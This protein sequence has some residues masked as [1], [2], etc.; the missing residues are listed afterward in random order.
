MST[1]KNKKKQK[2]A[3]TRLLPPQLKQNPSFR[4]VFRFKSTGGT[5]NVYRNNILS[6]FSCASAASTAR[7]FPI[8]AIKIRKVSMWVLDPNPTSLQEINFTWDGSEGPTSTQSAYGNVSFPAKIVTRPPPKCYASSWQVQGS[9][10]G[11]A[12]DR[13]FFISSQSG[14]YVLDL[15]CDIVL[16]GVGISGAATGVGTAAAAGVYYHHL[17]CLDA[18]GTA[19]GTQL[20][21]PTAF[22]VDALASRT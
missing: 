5:S 4:R 17:D 22:T 10:I 15:D 9:S 1:R 16:E 6:L 20:L 8:S 18:A 3:V 21:V 19:A 12:S 11:A 13:L 2:Q 7:V 14:D